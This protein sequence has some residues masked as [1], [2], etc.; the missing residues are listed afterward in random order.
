MAKYGPASLAIDYDNSGGT[1][2]SITQHVLTMNGVSIEQ[3]LEEVRSFGDQWE[4]HLPIGVGRMKPVVLGGKFDDTAATGPD[5]LFI[6]TTPETPASTT[7]TLKFTWGG[8]KTTSVETFVMRYDRL[9]E[10][11]KIQD[12][13]V[14]L[15]PTGAV[16]EV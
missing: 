6:R 4:E 10:R 1:P 12:Y 5:A 9:G 11:N 8:T 15:Q 14:E 2:V 13:E 16:T 3:I 7:R